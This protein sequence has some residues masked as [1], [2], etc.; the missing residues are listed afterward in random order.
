MAV[1]CYKMSLDLYKFVSSSSSEKKYKEGVTVHCTESGRWNSQTVGEE[2]FTNAATAC[3]TQSVSPPPSVQ[4]TLSH[5]NS[6]HLNTHPSPAN[7]LHCIVVIRWRTL[8]GQTARCQ[9]VGR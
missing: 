2:R 6:K 8:V 3:L 9:M 5:R 4:L 1:Q 7:T